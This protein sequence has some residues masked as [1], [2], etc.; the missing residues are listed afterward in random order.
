MNRK[1]GHFRDQPSLADTSVSVAMKM[2]IGTMQIEMRGGLQVTDEADNRII[3]R[4]CSN[5]FGGSL[6]SVR[7]K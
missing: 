3:A 1:C 6:F 5:P 4:C 7:A 2:N